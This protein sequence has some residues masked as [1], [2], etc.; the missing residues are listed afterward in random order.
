MGTNT[1]K[2]TGPASPSSL[3]EDRRSTL[4][5]P[6]LLVFVFICLFPVWI[7]Q[8]DPCDAETVLI[9][10]NFR[11]A[12]EALPIVQDLI[13]PGGRASVDIRSNALVITGDEDCIKK[14]R[15]FLARFDAPAPQAAIRVR[16][17]ETG[18]HESR[19]VAAGGRLSGDDWS[20]RKGPNRTHGIDV[21]VR[22]FKTR[23]GGDSEYF[24]QVMS[25][26][27]AYIRVGKNVLFRERWIAVYR[28]H[29]PAREL[30]AIQR[31]ETGIE[32]KPFITGNRA[33]IEILPRI[34]HA[35][36]RGNERIIHFAEAST[37]IS[38][39]LGRWV[40]IGGADRRSHEVMR[41]ILESGRGEAG[42][43][44][45]ISLMVESRP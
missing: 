1:R 3:R 12:G 21:D 16:F 35:V 34:S 44:L 20:L 23:K 17:R 11:N 9:P 5:C 27:W 15:E 31:I 43:A 30:M 40:K 41:A 4:L 14:V 39:P 2:G 13:A 42:S 36:P 26:S 19:S 28:R 18:F 8:P 10:M 33:N 29:L 45:S 32:V 22:D 24:I 38:V 7:V 25:G 37:R 6:N